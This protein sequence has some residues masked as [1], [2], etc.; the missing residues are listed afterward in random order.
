MER[1][2]IIFYSIFGVYQLVAF[3]FTVVIDSNTSALFSMAGYVSWFKYASF[4]GLMLVVVDFVW[5]WRQ[6]SKAK[7]EV[8]EFRHENNT[9]KAKIYDIQETRKEASPTASK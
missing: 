4:V 2:R 3:I 1:N 6:N 7:R 9:L 8:E 5:S